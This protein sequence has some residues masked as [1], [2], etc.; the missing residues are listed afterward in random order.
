[1]G[2][3]QER[4]YQIRIINKVMTHYRNKVK[5]IGI[6][7]P[8]GAGKTIMALAIAKQL[9][10]E[11]NSIGWVAMRRVLLHQAA[12]ANQE[13]FGIKNIKF[14]SMFDKEPPPCD[15]LIADE[16][17]HCAASSFVNIDSKH[18]PK[19][20][21][22]M[23]ATPFRTD[24]LKLPFQKMV[25][26]AGI[27]RLIQEGWLSKYHHYA[28][29]EYTPESVAKTYLQDKEKWGKTIIFFR[30]AEECMECDRLINIGGGKSTILLGST[31]MSQREDI[32]E[33]FDDRKYDVLINIMVLAEGFDCC[34]LKTVFVRDS[35]KL[36]TMQ[37]GGRAFR[38]HP[39]KSYCNV[40][41][42][43]N[44]KYQFTRVAK[45]E[46][47]YTQRFGRWLSLGNSE[48]AMT[49]SKNMR[50][51]VANINVEIPSF[52]RAR[53]SKRRMIKTGAA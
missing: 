29:D 2:Q 47:S 16:L 8:T 52:I 19:L 27:H 45:P 28:M 10:G 32:L 53:K 18:P 11:G 38:I 15:I 40:V 26:D 24:N 34:D 5:S 17:Q 14:I 9:E 41:Q 49:V 20:L 43:V 51:I 37:M 4:D 42:S 7:S 25:T 30:T 33:Q 3:I 12:Q 39:D 44:S 35:A 21:L 1:M 22:G 36:P 23:S 31:P 6:V 13:F 48:K 46:E 50:I